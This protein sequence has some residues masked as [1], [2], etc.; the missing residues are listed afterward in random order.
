MRRAIVT[1]I[2]VGFALTSGGCAGFD[3]SGMLRA[4]L[5]DVAPR[6]AEPTAEQQEYIPHQAQ[7]VPE[8]RQDHAIVS[9]SWRVPA[10]ARERRSSLAEPDSR[11]R[12]SGSSVNAT[13]PAQ[14]LGAFVN[15]V[16]GD[17]LEL[18]YTLGPG[19]ADRNDVVTLRSVRDMDRETFFQLFEAAIG[20]Y[21]LAAAYRDGLVR[22]VERSELQASR[23]QFIRS[24]ARSD[25][26][27]SLRPIVQFVQ[28]EAIDAAEMEQILRVSFPGRSELGIQMRRDV[29]A[30]TLSGLSDNV[31]A[32]LAIILQM[33]DLR[34][35][36]SDAATLAPR[37]WR[38]S[39]LTQAL[40]DILT[41]EGYQI[42]LGPRAVRPVTLIP[43]P[44]TNQIIVFADSER[45]MG[46]LIAT[47]R[48]LDAAAAASDA[49]TP[50]IFQARAR[51]AQTLA[52]I[53]ARIMGETTS[54]DTRV[55][56]ETAQRPQSQPGSRISVDSVGNRIIFVGTQAEFRTLERL[57]IDLDTAAPEVLIEVTIAEV[58]LTEE[59]RYGF[60]F[61]LNTYGGD[62]ELRTR[63]GLG[64]ESGGISAVLRAGD[65]D[66]QAAARATNTQINILSTPRVT[67]RS[68]SSA[69]VQVGT[70]VPIIT[71]QR[72]A[73]TQQSGSTDILQTIQFRSTGVLLNVEPRVYSDDR[74]DLTISQEVSAAQPNPNQSIASPIISNRS[75]TSEITLQD[76]QTAILGGL[77]EQRVNRGTTGVPGLQNV[78]VVGALFSTMSFNSDRTVLLVMVTPY[79]LRNRDDRQRMAELY[80]DE[81][82]RA[83]A[84]P[85]RTGGRLVPA[86]PALQVEVAR[87]GD[88]E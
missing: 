79:I 1:S 55:E 5:A 52:E 74:I 3:E 72:A 53:A 10:M 75:L 14:P 57:L 7:D 84:T 86:G 59:Q 35:S 64:L 51:E 9:G 69:S 21:G 24:R 2:V 11:P 29:N 42:G 6:P 71:S 87:P 80:A 32:A 27:A 8:A 34:F 44:Q 70:D 41:T 37:N 54:A 4:Q 33:D 46:H 22:I 50:H 49:R 39:E 40:I 88:D 36:N 47:A 43:V 18:P 81:I 78:P 83:F 31:D 25:V 58:T 13:I 66:I 26:P 82:N 16:L 77:M 61:L 12:L 62:V 60:E 17:I 73:T 28:L 19:V 85:L 67:A 48:R 38:A 15:T 63:G 23:P 56:S 65:V 30:L 45:A 76:G 68:G 20:E